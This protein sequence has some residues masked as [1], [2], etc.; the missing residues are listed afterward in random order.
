MESSRI[1]SRFSVLSGFGAAYRAAYT[2]RGCLGFRA[3]SQKLRA[4]GD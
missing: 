1:S 3:K 2:E 4:K